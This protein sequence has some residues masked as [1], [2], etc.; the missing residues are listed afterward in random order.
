MKGDPKVIEYLNRVLRNELTA[1]N[2]YF[3]HSR[4]FKD[5]GLKAIADYEFHESVDEMKHADALFDVKCPCNLATRVLRHPH[6]N[7]Q[8]FTRQLAGVEIPAGLERVRIRAHDSVHA[9]GGAEVVV[10]LTEAE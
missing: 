5:W 6:V 7:E 3:L 1:I 9:D 8:P 2:Q 4:M 10:E